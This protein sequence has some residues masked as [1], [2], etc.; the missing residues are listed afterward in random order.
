[1]VVFYTFQQIGV[2]WVNNRVLDDA[3]KVLNQLQ[4][5]GKR[6]FFVTNNATKSRD[7][8]VELARSRGFNVTKEQILTPILSIVNYLHSQNFNKKI[9]TIGD[10]IANELK[11]WNLNCVNPSNDKIIDTHHSNITVDMLNLDPDVG[12][13]L[14]NYTYSFHYSHIL[15]AANYLKDPNCLFLASCMDD[16]IPSDKNLIL[17]GISPIARAIEACSYRKI[18]NLGKP[19]PMLCN[20]LL[21]DGITNPQRTLMIGDN[22]RTDIL[23]GKSCGFH[24][25][26]VGSGVHGLTDIQEWQNSSN[27]DDKQLIPDAYINKITDL[28]TFL[29]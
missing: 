10:S 16:R 23:L 25:L 7:I 22:A 18:L 11:Q 15:R 19:N 4:E 14:V 27:L 26:L 20:K 13:V 2:L 21:N 6:V 17:P 12:A 24:T 28:M 8:L 3:N 29:K 1:M 9:Y 5:M